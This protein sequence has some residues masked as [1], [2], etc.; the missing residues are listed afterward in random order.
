MMKHVEYLFVKFVELRGNGQIV[1]RYIC[2]GMKI[3]LET[4]TKQE[5]IVK[6]AADSMQ[7]ISC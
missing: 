4:I 1:S 2:N 5:T 7:L 3:I 6:Y